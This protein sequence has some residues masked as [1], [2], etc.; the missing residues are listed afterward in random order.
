[1]VTEAGTKAAD[2]EMQLFGEV[3]RSISKIVEQA[4]FTFSSAHQIELITRQQ[5]TSV[6]QVSIALNEINLAA[7]QTEET[8]NQTLKTIKLLVT[9][10]SSLKKLI[11]S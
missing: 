1:M 7:K 2:D 10:S 6:E 3:I 4:D 11:T 9:M 5:T 8:A